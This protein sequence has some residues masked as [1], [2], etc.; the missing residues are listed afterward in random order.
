MVNKEKLNSAV[1]AVNKSVNGLEVK[2]SKDVVEQISLIVSALIRKI[3]HL[4]LESLHNISQKTFTSETILKAIIEVVPID[5]SELFINYS[6]SILNNYKQRN[7]AIT[8]STKIASGLIV[9]PSLV[10]RRMR[11]NPVEDI[12]IG[13]T[14]KI[15][16]A[17]FVEQLL[18]II[19]KESVGELY[20]GVVKMRDVLL[21]V[22]SNQC[23]KDLFTKQNIF[24]LHAG[25]TNY[26]P[27]FLTLT[28][29][30]K[31]ANDNKRK[32]EAKR[33]G[34]K[35]KPRETRPGT[36]IRKTIIKSQESTKN[37]I[38]FELGKRIVD[39]ILDADVGYRTDKNAIID[40]INYAE[41]RLINL[42]RET[43]DL[44]YLISN[45]IS[46]DPITLIRVSELHGIVL[47][48]SLVPMCRNTALRLAERAGSTR[49]LR[50]DKSGEETIESAIGSIL[51]SLVTEIV[52]AS[53]ANLYL[54][55]KSTLRPKNVYEASLSCGYIIPTYR[56][57][58]Q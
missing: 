56:R 45:K 3:Y 16:I 25:V 37:I 36:K 6:R 39:A 55:K 31:E 14:A 24:I 23:L 54:Y 46:L 49:R 58:K 50:K 47:R 44:T 48:E 15:T 28:K 33:K 57:T 30:K 38:G 27:E 19:L 34:I 4:A 22:E 18:T 40:I 42:I 11:F 51:E 10:T 21:A 26:S 41:I 32:L 13:I 1:K 8:Q 7:T 5:S 17:S 9:S 29:A 52:N 35:L 53:A 20:S 12:R 43:L 2:L